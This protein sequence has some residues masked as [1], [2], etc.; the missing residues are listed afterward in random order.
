[1]WAECEGEQW[2]RKGKLAYFK[3]CLPCH[4]KKWPQDRRA[5]NRH[6]RPAMDGPGKRV[7]NGVCHTAVGKFYLTKAGQLDDNHDFEKAVVKPPKK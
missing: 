6:S 1:M 4:L 5:R 2:E 7:A 3:R